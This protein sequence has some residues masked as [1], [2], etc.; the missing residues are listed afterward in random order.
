MMYEVV[1]RWLRAT[2][3]DDFSGHIRRVQLTTLYRIEGASELNVTSRALAAV[4]ETCV[5]TFTWSPGCAYSTQ[6]AFKSH[7]KYSERPL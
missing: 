1:I 3:D 4:P 6:A 5:S 7:H 2:A